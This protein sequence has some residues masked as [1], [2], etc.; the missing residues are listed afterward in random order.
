MKRNPYRVP[1]LAAATN[2]FG[3]NFRKQ[4]RLV[5]SAL[6][7]KSIEIFTPQ[8]VCTVEWV[9]V[10]VSSA[11]TI[12]MTLNDQPYGAA[13]TVTQNAVIRFAGTLLVENERLGLTVSA[14]TTLSYEV[15]WLKEFNIMLLQNVTEVMFVGGGPAS[16]TN[17]SIFDSAG[18]TLSSNSAGSLDV[19]PFKRQT[20]LSTTPLGANGVFTGPWF[21]TQVT[22]VTQVMSTGISNVISATPGGLVISESEDQ[23]NFN[24]VGVSGNVASNRVT[25]FIRARYWRATYTNGPTP[26]GSFSLIATE[27]TTPFTGDPFAAA[28]GNQAAQF[29]LVTPAFGQPATFADAVANQ[30]A[31]LFA[32]AITGGGTQ[33]NACFLFNG[34]TWDRP[35]NTYNIVTGDS[36]AKVA[37]FNGAAQTNFDS[38]SA[39]IT[40][41]LG[42]VSGTTPTLAA[43]F[44]WSPDGGTTWLNLGAVLPNLTTTGQSGTIVVSPYVLTGL[45]LGSTVS[46]LTT[47]PVPRTW[48]LTYTIAGTTPSFTIGSVNVNY[49]DK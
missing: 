39:F 42:T 32:N 33:R 48:R 8:T 12:Q 45:T 19:A 4:N 35:R 7:S 9:M 47:S 24:T 15:A 29:N 10:Q 13:L 31:S 22:G 20:I 30:S 3:P 1:G 26:Q 25:A 5:N 28:S 49:T 2:N 11:C 37:S 21:D 46:V 23:I 34:V 40:I 41:L 6:V 16:S 36:G 44:Q 38:A 43:Q 17:V 18:N 14:P 27:S